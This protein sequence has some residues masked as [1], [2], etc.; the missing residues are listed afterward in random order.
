MKRIV[1]FGRKRAVP[2]GRERKEFPPLFL[3]VF[4]RSAYICF[5]NPTFDFPF[6]MYR[7]VEKRKSTYWNVT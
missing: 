5:T 6:G 4:E 7:N 3:S 2:L 1:P